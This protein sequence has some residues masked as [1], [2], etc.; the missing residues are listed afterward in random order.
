[1]MDHCLISSLGRRK[2]LKY[3]TTRLEIMMMMSKCSFDQQNDQS[4]QDFHPSRD[5]ELAAR[6]QFMQIHSIVDSFI[7]GLRHK[8]RGRI[9]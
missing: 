8:K 5:R 3:L 7:H 4:S 6:F 9:R 1:M 2:M